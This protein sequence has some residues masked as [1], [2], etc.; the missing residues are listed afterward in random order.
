MRKM[1]GRTTLNVPWKPK[2]PVGIA[3]FSIPT[4][5]IQ[6]ITK[7]GILY[8]TVC[9]SYA[10]VLLLAIDGHV[11]PLGMRRGACTMGFRGGT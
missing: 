8:V 3:L 6:V 4:N 11:S 5:S 9:T 7:A 10:I 1:H 2:L